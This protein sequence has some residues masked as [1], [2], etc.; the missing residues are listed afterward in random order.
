MSKKET[1]TSKWIQPKYL[2]A[3]GCFSALFTVMLVA[4]GVIYD[5]DRFPTWELLKESG[6]QFY[7]SPLIFVFAWFVIYALFLLLDSKKLKERS[8]LPRFTYNMFVPA[9]LFFLLYGVVYLSYYPG[10]WCYDIIQQNQMILGL[11]ELTKHHPPLHT[12]L[13]G[14]CLL[15]EKITAGKVLGI[16]FYSILQIIITSLVY[17]RV[18]YSIR[19]VTKNDICVLLAF[20]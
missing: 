13:W 7:L 3:S 5:R 14:L 1:K 8:F 19:K 10:T 9:A 12:Y 16:V 20:A 15:V 11:E 17:G 18:V 6:K 4:G 2:I